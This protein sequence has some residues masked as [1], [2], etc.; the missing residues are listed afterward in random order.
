MTTIIRLWAA[1][2]D[3]CRWLGPPRTQEERAD[4]DRRTHDRDHHQDTS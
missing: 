2:C 3:H 4:L 1:H